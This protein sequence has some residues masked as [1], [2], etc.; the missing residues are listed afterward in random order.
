MPHLIEKGT[1]FLTG[2]VSQS[3]TFPKKCHSITHSLC[4]MHWVD[5]NPVGPPC[6]LGSSLSFSNGLFGGCFSR[7]RTRE[8]VALPSRSTARV[9]HFA[10]RRQVWTRWQSGSARGENPRR[11]QSVSSG[12]VY[13]RGKFP[14]ECGGICLD[15]GRGRR[16]GGISD[17]LGR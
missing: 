11:R 6:I 12:A 7:E 17:L 9:P 4:Q 14:W 15:L 16:G 10:R 5:P 8:W 3:F 1:T 13:P 2:T